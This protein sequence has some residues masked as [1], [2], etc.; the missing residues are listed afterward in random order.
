MTNTTQ[1]PEK[2]NG[3]RVWLKVVLFTS[4]ALNL[5]VAGLVIG[6]AVKYGPRDGG[7][8]GRHP[9]RLER[10]VGPY[11]HAL[12]HADK[13]AIGARLRAEYRDNR[14]SREQIRAEFSTVLQAL[15]ARPYDAQQVEAILMRQMQAGA[16]R[17]ELG[18]RLL[19]ER[20]SAMSDAERA[21]Y[22]DRLEDGLKRHGP[23]GPSK[24]N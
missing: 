13:R 8:D 1:P 3:M 15:R 20:L 6:A 14:P 4:L 16:E 10:I 18:Q 19:I 9:P 11:T 24:R 17:Q 5:A 21:A 22:A 2:K 23:P 12:S 7:R